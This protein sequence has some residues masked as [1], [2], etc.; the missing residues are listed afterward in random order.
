[1]RVNPSS[2]LKVLVLDDVLIGLD[3]SNR[4]P[5]IDILKD[6]FNDYQVFLMLKTQ[7]A[8]QNILRKI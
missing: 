2:A 5:I 8:L 3:M 4:L 6:Q 7:M 1:M